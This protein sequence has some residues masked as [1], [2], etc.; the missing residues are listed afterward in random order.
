MHGAPV[1]EVAVLVV[2]LAAVGL[3]DRQMVLVFGAL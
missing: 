3:I 2:G 1:D